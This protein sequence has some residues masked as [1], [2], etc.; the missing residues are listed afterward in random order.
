MET[1]VAKPTPKLEV[2]QLVHYEGF[3][4]NCGPAMKIT[5]I[6]EISECGNFASLDWVHSP[7]RVSELTIPESISPGDLKFWSRYT[8]Y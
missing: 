6:K 1:D 3:P 8:P 5:R 4:D 2:N 7:V